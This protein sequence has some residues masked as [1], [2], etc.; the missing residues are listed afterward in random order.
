MRSA[1]A[2]FLLLLLLQQRQCNIFSP[3]GLK[4]KIEDALRPYFPNARGVIA[5]QQQTLMGFTCVQGVG[6]EF[7]AK[8]A[9]SIVA[10]RKTIQDLSYIQFAPL[11][12]GAHY[13]YFWLVF[14]G[15]FIR[16]DLDTRQIAA[17]NSTPQVLQAYR[18]TCGF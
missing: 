4:G 12:G 14:D 15:G 13:K 5:P 1:P 16:Y 6:S 9:A 17:F 3:E 18:Q 7:V 8:V 2:F 11:L 10:D